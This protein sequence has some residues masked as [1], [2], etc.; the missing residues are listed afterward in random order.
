MHVTPMQRASPTPA[1]IIPSGTTIVLLL[2]IPSSILIVSLLPGLGI[3]L[4]VESS[5]P[6]VFVSKLSLEQPWSFVYGYYMAVFKL[7]KQRCIIVAKTVGSAKSET[8]IIWT[9]TGKG[10]RALI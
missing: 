5:Q 3:S 2:D 8:L 6:P 7:Q 10:Y 9:F 1:A 4:S